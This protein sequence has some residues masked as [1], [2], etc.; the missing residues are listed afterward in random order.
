M[1]TPTFLIGQRGGGF[2]CNADH[3]IGDFLRHA[4]NV[5]LRKCCHAA[6]PLCHRRQRAGPGTAGCHWPSR[7]SAK[8]FNRA[9]EGEVV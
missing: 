4:L 7:C 5:R 2:V 3:S 8:E 1:G 9:T 6:F